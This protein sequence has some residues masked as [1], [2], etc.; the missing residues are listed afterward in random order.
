MGLVSGWSA[1]PDGSCAAGPIAGSF[2]VDDWGHGGPPLRTC[3]IC[4]CVTFCRFPVLWL[5]GFSGESL[6]PSAVLLFLLTVRAPVLQTVSLFANPFD[7]GCGVDDL[8][9]YTR[10]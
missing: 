7:Q 9:G 4:P 3:G 10:R 6:F 8:M 1:A 5:G 2:G